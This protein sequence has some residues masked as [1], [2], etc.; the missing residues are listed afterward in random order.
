MNFTEIVEITERI[1]QV[2]NISNE[3]SLKALNAMLIARRSGERVRGFQVVSGELRRFSRNL[4]GSMANL[5]E[6]VF[7]LVVAVAESRRHY[8]LAEYY[9][10][11]MKDGGCAAHVGNIV[12]RHSSEAQISSRTIS[13]LRYRLLNSLIMTRRVCAMGTT[14]SRAARIEAV[15]GGTFAKELTQVATEVEVTVGCIEDAIKTLEKSFIST[16]SSKRT[17]DEEVTI[18]LST[19]KP[20]VGSDRTRSG[21]AELRDRHQR[22]CGGLR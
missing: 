19:R 18:D 6:L 10:D 12:A 16:N 1:K 22:V 9:R 17:V 15:H 3:V 20:Q 11:L 14:I 2:L 4:E 21:E 7:D 8:R 5:I 13:E